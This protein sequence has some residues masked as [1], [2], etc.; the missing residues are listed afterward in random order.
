MLVERSCWRSRILVQSVIVSV[1][2]Q[3]NGGLSTHPMGRTKGNAT[4]AGSCGRFGK[5]TPSVGKAAVDK[6]IR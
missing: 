1:M 4:S 6:A 2:A 3:N 5:A